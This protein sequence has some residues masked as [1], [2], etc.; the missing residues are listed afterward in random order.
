MAFFS[1]ERNGFLTV[2]ELMDSVIRQMV[3]H[4]FAIEYQNNFDISGAG[5]VASAYKVI[6]SAGP[7]ID[8]LAPAA[9]G[10]PGQPWWICFDILSNQRCAAYVG[11]PLQ[12]NTQTGHINQITNAA[13]QSVDTC[14]A[15]GALVLEANP[16]ATDSSQGFLNREQR[17]GTNASTYPLTYR[18]SV[19]DRGVFLGVWEGSWS[20][21]WAPNTDSTA[22]EIPTTPGE[23][24]MYTG[25]YF[26][27]LLVQRPVDRF[28]GATLVQGKC[29]VF[30]VNQVN[31]K[32][33]KFV[34]RESDI[35]HPTPRVRADANKE[36]SH[37]I[38]NIANQ[39]ALTE[40]KK[41]LLT[42]PHNLTTPR[43]RYT[44]ELDLIG[45]TSSDVV[46]ASSEVKFR[47]YGESDDRV[48]TALLPSGGFNTGARIC[49]LTKEAPKFEITLAEDGGVLS[50]AVV[51]GGSGYDPTN[52]PTLQFVDSAQTPGTG[53]TATCTV[54]ADGQITSVAV[55]TAGAGYSADV[56]INLV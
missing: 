53:A 5:S 37:M 10:Q 29:P 49:V 24:P 2:S 22:S 44:E 9:P 51:R 43:F 40:D 42:F 13:G 35:L 54:N 4:G 39:V 56:L 20:T 50:V 32:Y 7:D 48:Y 38:F 27:W 11:T 17:V 36:D 31:Y 12:F 19:S 46:M 28:T 15:V 25:N 6:L 1:V 3:S 34:V 33:W 8:P 41:Y 30:C 21:I 16:L 18:L 45:V 55:S 14:G 23:L 52:P 26:N 47:V